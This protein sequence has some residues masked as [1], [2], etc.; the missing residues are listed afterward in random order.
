MPISE[1][2]RRDAQ[3][4]LSAA[5][6]NKM[7]SDEDFNRRVERVWGTQDSAELAFLISDLNQGYQWPLVQDSHRADEVVSKNY[8]V[9]ISYS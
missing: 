5:Y 3:A 6:A 7:L 2:E 4:K 1:D 9:P 8:G